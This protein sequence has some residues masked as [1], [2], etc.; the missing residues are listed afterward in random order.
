MYR[1]PPFFTRRILIVKTSAL[2]DIVQSFV[3]LNYLK[4]KFPDV[5]IDWVVEKRFASIVKAHPQVSRAIEFESKAWKSGQFR[6]YFRA[7]KELR[8]RSYDFVFDLQGNC[9]SGIATLLSKGRCKV[10][11]GWKNVREW[12][13]LLATNLRFELPSHLN[14]RLQLLALVQQAL[15]D[16]TLLPTSFDDVC[17]RISLEETM[18]IEA[19][20]NKVPRK[21]R[22]MVCPGSKWKNKQLPFNTL[23]QF[24]DKIASSM[25]VSFFFIW[26]NAEERKCCEEL[27]QKFKG[28][29]VVVDKLE[30]PVWQNLM[31]EMQIVIAFDSGALHLAGTTSTPTFSIF[32]PTMPEIFKPLGAGHF[33][34]R[35]ECP[36]QR[37]FEKQCSL[38]RSCPSGAC[39]RN[40][41]VKEIFNLFEKWKISIDSQ[42]RCGSPPTG[43]PAEL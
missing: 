10:G 28:N 1:A 29:S 13:N 19:L 42:N 5:E 32:G 40:L 20:L 14:I 21:K 41:E 35:G 9:K 30:L 6:E 39:I 26:G 38:L 16:C 17:F 8:G 23:S 12:P 18:R 3:I 43:S 15:G 4:K 2:G 22:I 7:I 37:K 27:Q 36:Y 33:S 34:V 11:F 31:A 25:E 24:L